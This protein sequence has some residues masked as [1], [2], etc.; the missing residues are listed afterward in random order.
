M[1]S[2]IYFGCTTPFGEN[3]PDD[4]FYENILPILKENKIKKEDIEIIARHI[5]D[6]CETA[7]GNGMESEAFNSVEL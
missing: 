4:I 2:K 5:A 7:Y 1:E 3:K 6:M